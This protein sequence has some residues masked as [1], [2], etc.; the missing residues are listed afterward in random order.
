MSQLGWRVFRS[1]GSTIR[2]DTRGYSGGRPR[3]VWIRHT[4]DESTT[5]EREQAGISVTITSHGAV[6]A[7][8]FDEDD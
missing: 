2:S 5:L 6:Y 8:D 4:A 7:P 3:G 1:Q